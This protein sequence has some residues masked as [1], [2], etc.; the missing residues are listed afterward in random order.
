MK[1]ITKYILFPVILGMLFMTFFLK[2]D[3]NLT[4]EKSFILTIPGVVFVIAIT[5]G[6]KTISFLHKKIK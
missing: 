2:F 3:K 1:P 6:R 5:V 4:W